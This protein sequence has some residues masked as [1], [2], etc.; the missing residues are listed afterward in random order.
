MVSGVAPLL[1]WLSLAASFV[2]GLSAVLRAGA[3][4]PDAAGPA[5]VIRLPEEMSATIA[6]LFGL[7]GLVFL[8]HLMRRALAVR[9]QGEAPRGGVPRRIPP[10]LRTLTQV[11]SLL[12][13][14]LFAYLLWRGAIPLAGLLGLSGSGPAGSFAFPV[15]VSPSA[16]RVI[17]W[18][19]GILALATG[20]GALALAVW[21]ALADRQMG[22][23]EDE[24]R[25]R[26]DTLARPLEVA[27]E[28]SL[29]ALRSDADPRRAIVRCY[30]RFERAASASGVA[31]EPWLTPMEFMREAIVRLPVPGGAVPTLTGLF[32]LARFSDH[33]LGTRDR[34]RAI[35]ALG[36]IRS[37]LDAKGGDAGAP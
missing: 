14:A 32:E 20:A 6:L 31:R 37:A 23:P 19:F 1:I 13:F 17:T 11:L 29:A 35:E 26:H 12:N 25:Q 2:I 10:W 28:E 4:A 7:A 16:P 30:A 3:P 33:A 27:V 36:A 8:V 9:R 18:T 34:D 5:G 21:V 24:E 15:S 22:D